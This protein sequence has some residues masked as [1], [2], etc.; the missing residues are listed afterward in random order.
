MNEPKCPYCHNDD[1]SLIE[2]I[3]DFRSINGDRILKFLC[4]V[5]SK[6]WSIKE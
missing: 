4:G 1:K 2:K 3:M 6:Q 5:C